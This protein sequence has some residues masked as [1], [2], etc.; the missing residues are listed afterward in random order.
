MN[1]VLFSLYTRNLLCKT[2]KCLKLFTNVIIRRILN[3]SKIEGDG[4]K[5]LKGYVFRLYPDKIK[6]S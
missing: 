4:M 1:V 3:T 6:K 5:I 2:N